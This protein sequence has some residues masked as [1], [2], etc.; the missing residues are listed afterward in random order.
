AQAADLKRDLADGGAKADSLI[1][2]VSRLQAADDRSLAAT[3][4]AIRPVEAWSG[5]P[6]L[7]QRRQ[8]DFTVED[9]TKAIADL[10]HVIQVEVPAMYSSVAKKAWPKPVAA[11]PVSK[12]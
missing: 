11:V 10:N 5:M 1:A 8:I 7:D 4:G 3:N 12:K 9:A 2:R 6:T